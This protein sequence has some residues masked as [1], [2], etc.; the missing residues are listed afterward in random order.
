MLEP[1]QA[2]FYDYHDPRVPLQA[3]DVRYNRYHPLLLNAAFLGGLTKED[4]RILGFGVKDRFVGGFIRKPANPV[5]HK[6]IQIVLRAAQ[7]WKLGVNRLS[8]LRK[9][10]V[11]EMSPMVR[12]QRKTKSRV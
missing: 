9:R 11:R 7:N 4:E 2:I 1:R 6:E 12:L 3:E 10:L 8:G 5:L